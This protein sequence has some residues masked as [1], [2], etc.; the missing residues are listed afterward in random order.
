MLHS[1]EKKYKQ[2][3]I[4]KRL[5]DEVTILVVMGRNKLQLLF[6]LKKKKS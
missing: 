5:I 6:L 2:E 1:S 4:S 3:Q